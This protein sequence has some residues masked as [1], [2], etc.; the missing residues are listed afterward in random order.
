MRTWYSEKSD[1][2][3]MEDEIERLELNGWNFHSFAV[4]KGTLVVMLFYMDEK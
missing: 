1:W 4:L 2:T 3:T